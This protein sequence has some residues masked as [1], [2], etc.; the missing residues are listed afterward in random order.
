MTF[1]DFLVSREAF[2]IPPA[3]SI[4]SRRTEYE[5]VQISRAQVSQENVQEDG[6][7]REATLQEPLR[8]TPRP[9]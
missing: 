2:F 1:N 4:L 9:P 6:S 3:A 5:H 7:K 8:L